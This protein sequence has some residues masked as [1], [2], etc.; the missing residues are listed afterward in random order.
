[1]AFNSILYL[2]LSVVGPTV[3]MSETQQPNCYNRCPV[4]SP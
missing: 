1:M 2:N 4:L 3:R